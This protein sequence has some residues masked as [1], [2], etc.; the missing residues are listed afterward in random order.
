MFTVRRKK[1]PAVGLIVTCPADLRGP[2][3]R[4]TIRVDAPDRT[5]GVR[6]I[7]DYILASPTAA[8]SSHSGGQHLRRTTCDRNLLE[9]A[10]GEKRDVGAI[11]RPEGITCALSGGQKREAAGGPAPHG[12]NG[13]SGVFFRA[14]THTQRPL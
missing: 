1:G 11:R 2:R 3:H 13:E 10:V 9:F 7:D 8:P 14:P 6:R 4:R 5:F 12:E